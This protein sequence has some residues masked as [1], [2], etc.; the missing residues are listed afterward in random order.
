MSELWFVRSWLCEDGREVSLDE[1]PFDRHLAEIVLA[2][3]GVDASIPRGLTRVPVERAS[4][5][6]AGPAWLYEA[7]A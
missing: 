4:L 7:T 3:I 6:S 5:V 2:D 1:G